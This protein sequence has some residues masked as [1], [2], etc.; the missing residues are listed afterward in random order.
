MAKA[1]GDALSAPFG[2][3]DV[4][5]DPVLR[6][7]DGPAPYIAG[8]WSLHEVPVPHDHLATV[9]LWRAHDAMLGRRT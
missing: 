8:D 9:A 5:V 1:T 4:E 6:L 7:A 3:L 2:H